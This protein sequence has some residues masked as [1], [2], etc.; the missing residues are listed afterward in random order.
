[1]ADLESETAASSINRRG[2]G[3]EWI[4][5]LTPE[6]NNL[7]RLSINVVIN[8][9]LL[10]FKKAYK[11]LLFQSTILMVQRYFSI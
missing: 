3:V 8:V 2:S 9:S 4:Y 11:L 10:L 7:N 6:G 5:N 1:M